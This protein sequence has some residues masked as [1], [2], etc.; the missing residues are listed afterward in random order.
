MQGCL[1]IHLP[2]SGKIID[3]QTGSSVDGAVI[4]REFSRSA[5]M[6]GTEDIKLYERLTQTDG[7]YSFPLDVFFYFP[8]LEAIH[9]EVIIYKPGYDLIRNFDGLKSKYEISRLPDNSIVRKDILNEA[10]GYLLYKTTPNF[11]L[12]SAFEHNNIKNMSSI[13]TG[14]L[15]NINRNYGDNVNNITFDKSGKLYLLTD[16]KLIIL[17]PIHNGYDLKNATITDKNLFPVDN[18]TL[19]GFIPI[20]PNKDILYKAVD[21]IIDKD[22]LYYIAYSYLSYLNGIAIFDA[23]KKFIRWQNLSNIGNITG[24]SSLN[25]FIFVSESAGFYVFDM[26]FKLISYQPLPF[27]IFGTVYISRLKVNPTGDT[28]F[29]LDR[30]YGRVIWFDLIK[31]QWKHA[32]SDNEA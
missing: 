16:N 17:S 31:N 10:E 29:I 5:G 1:S 6:G 26:N 11:K 7:E 15:Y 8:Y 32:N 25:S 21:Y 4:A 19:S 9:D 12:L 20:F 24:I 30:N 3:K 14:V 23:N 18:T 2:A 28:L 13:T 22:G 27:D